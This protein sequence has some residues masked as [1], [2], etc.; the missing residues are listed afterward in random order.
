MSGLQRK[1]DP[2]VR[3][4]ASNHA[5]EVVATIEAIK[6]VLASGGFDLNDLADAMARAPLVPAAAPS[7]AEWRLQAMYLLDHGQLS[8]WKRGF[9]QSL[10]RFKRISDKQRTVL[11][12]L[13]EKNAREKEA[14]A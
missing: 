2:L 6:R 10:L 12:R 4:L 1:L 5:G 14:A 7:P 3:R 11:N 13:F 8:E 9:L